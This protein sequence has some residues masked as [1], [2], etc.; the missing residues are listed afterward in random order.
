L[1]KWRFN[2]PLLLKLTSLVLVVT[3]L[4]VGVTT[5][6]V[7]R[8]AQRSLETRA[9]EDLSA[10]AQMISLS[11]SEALAAQLSD[12]GALQEQVEFLE[13]LTKRT[14]RILDASGQLVAGSTPSGFDLKDYFAAYVNLEDGSVLQVFMAKGEIS[15][16][17]RR[18]A[19]GS[20]LIA[21]VVAASAV[22]VAYL[23]NR[24]I[25]N[26]IQDLLAMV[27]SLQERQFGR[28]V[29]VRSTD[30]IG[31]LGR[32][33]NELSEI[34]DDLFETIS[35]REGQLDTILSS[36]DDGVIAVNMRR[37]IILANRAAA[38]L[39][40]LPEDVIGQ[41][42]FDATRHEELMRILE[43]TMDAR[44][45]F[46]SEVRVRPGSERTVAI[47]SSPLQDEKGK[48]QGAVAVMR[49]VTS[50]R[51][52]EQMRQEFVSNVSHELRTPLTS[53]KGFV[54][55]LLNGHLDD[56]QLLERFLRIIAAE[57]DR[58]IALI[59]DLLDLSRIE[60]GKLKVNKAAVDMKKIFD[61]TVL[62]LQSRAEEKQITLE[63]N[64]YNPIIV[65]GDEKL[66]RQVAL[67]LVDNGVKYT[68]EGGRVWIEAEEGLDHV[69]FIVGDNGVGIPSEHLDRI[70]ERFY[71]VDKGRSRQTGGTG[72]GLA[73]VKHIIDRHK[74]TIAI[75]SRVGK[76]TK[77][78]ITLKKIS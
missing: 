66:L 31:Q 75:E 37:E 42:L 54:E 26:P 58:M 23:V 21:I 44:E 40:D 71:R 19:R 28:M 73:I 34:L 12:P 5:F 65:E 22:A 11:L 25:T 45:T 39:W 69:E 63:N 57:T 38:D 74:G 61:D 32:A 59:N 17:S 29:L 27:R 20:I 67:N 30:E 62:L 70:F 35:S 6:F 64:I 72:L 4:S 16:M 1:K 33:F 49:D 2:G 78:R 53:I 43:K 7:A 36:M 52:L 15:N 24:S 55:T 51:H 46:T 76:G 8:L 41:N 3:L 13:R 77:I 14:I 56:Q 68:Q 60:S 18:I 9:R 10:D 48:I 50:L 47:T